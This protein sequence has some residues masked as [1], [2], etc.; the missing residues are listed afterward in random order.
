MRLWVVLVLTLWSVMKD[1]VSRTAT[2]ASLRL[3]RTFAPSMSLY[4]V[5]CSLYWTGVDVLWCWQLWQILWRVADTRVVYQ[6]T[7]LMYPHNNASWT[8]DYKKLLISRYFCSSHQTAP[9]NTHLLLGMCTSFNLQ[10]KAVLKLLK[11]PLQ[12]QPGTAILRRD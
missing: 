4:L 6:L 5:V 11:K 1:I 9:H 10:L 3:S 12:S 2:R 8:D 7:Q